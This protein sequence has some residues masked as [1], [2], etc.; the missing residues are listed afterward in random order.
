M[1]AD[2]PYETLLLPTIPHGF[3]MYKTID[4]FSAVKTSK[5]ESIVR[6][7]GKVISVVLFCRV[8]RCCIV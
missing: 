5:F 6:N 7:C 4:I 3:S 2:F 1:E 8:F